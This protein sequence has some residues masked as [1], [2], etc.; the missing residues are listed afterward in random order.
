MK[1]LFT[2]FM[3]GFMLTMTTS[4]AQDLEQN[5][6][7][8]SKAPV[9]IDSNK[10]IV[11][12][13]Y[14]PCDKS[15]K[16]CNGYIE[17]IEV[18]GR[19]ITPISY[20]AEGAYTLDKQMLKEYLYG[21]GNLN[22][23]LGLLPGVQFSD[24]A[25][26]ANQVTNIKPNE[27]SIAGALGYQSGYQIDG[28]GNNSKLSKGD[29]SAGYN[30]AHN[31]EGHSQ[32]AFVNLK[33]L[34]QVEVYDSNIPARYGQFSGGLVLAKTQ[35]AG[36]ETRFG[37]SYRQT[38]DQL[39]EYHKFYAP[40][41][42]GEDV[43][44]TAVFNKK[45]FNAYLSMPINDVSGV[46]AQIQVLRS[47]ESLN[48]LGN[49]REQEQ[50]NYNALLKYHYNVTAQDQ[51]IFRYLNA[52]YEGSYF[53]VD[54]INSNYDIDGGGQSFMAKWQADRQWGRM[55]SQFDWRQSQNSKK[56]ASARYVWA[57][58]PG[59]AWGS[60]NDSTTS[61]AGG[62]GDIKKVQD[63][64][65]LKQDFEI[66]NILETYGY[67]D[68][69]FGYHLEYQQTVFDR[70]EDSV[71]YNG[72]V[73]S[74]NI[75]CNGYVND[76]IETSF[77]RQLEEIETELGRSL[78]LADPADF[79]LYQDNL[80]TTGQY[81]QSRQVSPSSTAEAN[82]GYFSAYA[83][84]NIN[85]QELNIAAGLRYD[86]N[87]FFQNHNIAPRLRLSYEFISGYQMILGA[88]RYYESDLADYKLNQAIQPTHNEVRAIY[89]NRPQ[90]WQAALL[91]QGYR[92]EYNDTKTPFSDEL[93]AAYRQPLFGGIVELKWVRRANKDSINRIKGYNDQ[94]ESVLYAGNDGGS[95]YRRWSLSWMA[96]FEN[97]HVEFNLSHA[98][99]TTSRKSF[100]G[101]TTL[102]E[103]GDGRNTKTLNYSYDDN[104][105]V[106]LRTD[107]VGENG[108]NKTDFQLV[109]RHD[110]NL[111]RQDANRPIVVNLSWAGNWNNWQFS[112]YAR[113][114][115][116]QDA[117]YPTGITQSIKEAD[118]ICDECNPQQ[119]EYPVY[120]AKKRP[121]FWLVNGSI[122]YNWLLKDDSY[123][124]LSIDG[125]NLLNQRT[126]Q[127]SPSTT[128][129][130]LGRRFWLGISYDY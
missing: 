71:T 113:F 130:E 27:V 12:S 115:G 124:T 66:S 74:P 64:F 127:V 16:D 23:I 108:L 104:E 47:S 37:L 91:T 78:D 19:Q 62:F 110:I 31:V 118:T 119:K 44:E 86:Y 56:T 8:K 17:H 24:A 18:V 114:N 3:V 100:D 123:L 4:F 25:Y 30:H 121:S 80:L 111:E 87:D 63:T 36:K 58:L 75:N 34:E 125:E 128:G 39:V 38:A 57:N 43:L 13:E 84:D 81:F 83:E 102:E 90:Q 73:V 95:D 79:N 112:A 67:H 88:N 122:K 29:G 82:I 40:D 51:L 97:Q 120:R 26:A 54:A 106:F 22:D 55:D 59:K 28:V 99:N 98:S 10:K 15:V 50:T 107:S 117:I 129:L 32:E 20:S 53:D 103:E 52:P 89:N 2:L 116:S 48:Q 77:A 92:Y 11:K 6:A 109:T 94:G 35:N 14:V 105:L 41:F 126:Y 65:S 49:I 76:C 46:V 85:F 61:L 69:S 33:I 68:L 72:A 60:Y 9:V 96:Q 93:T 5:V 21:N 42:S 101:D 1:Y 7:V 45:D 70:L